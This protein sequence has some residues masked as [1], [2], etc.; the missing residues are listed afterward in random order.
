[1]KICFITSSFP[2]SPQDYAAPWLAEAARR[3]DAKGHQVSVFVPSHRGLQ[4]TA[5]GP[6][7]VHRFRYAPAAWERLTHEDSS[8][9]AL[10]RSLF[11]K[12][13]LASYLVCGCFSAFF[14]FLTR[15]FDA[16][17]V[18]WP[19]PQAVFGVIADLLGSRRLILHFYASELLLIK[20]S[21]TLKLAMK[22]ALRSANGA[23]AIS[24]YTKELVERELGPG[25]GVE[26]IPFGHT[27]G[28]SPGAQPPRPPAPGEP[29]R[30]LYAGKL[31]ERKGPLYLVEAVKLLKDSGV[32]VSLRM[33]GDGYL[34][35]QV[36]A[37]IAET[38]TA[39][40]IELLGFLSGEA[41]AAE[42]DRCHA[43]VFPSII[44]SRGD[45]EGQGL[46]PLDALMHGRPVIASAVGGVTDLVK[47]CETG[48]LVPE[49]DPAAIAAAVRRV[50]DDYPAALRTV[51]RG[52]AHASAYFSWDSVIEKF[53]KVYNA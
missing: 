4:Q 52:Q 22:Q 50:R 37:K 29:F 31:I 9:E 25:P 40:E 14:Y 35:D 18:H 38:G 41:M 17:V 45:T 46:A 42:F 21:R 43:L 32:P 7:A 19:F 51:E 47:D 53:L 15:R 2:R 33:S 3:L 49:K 30:L 23:I 16:V 28:G 10:R 34:K 6:T 1:M 12:L 11:W 27:F 36:L 48:F 20:D 26:V 24:T 39:G 8:P 44:D 5:L 13:V